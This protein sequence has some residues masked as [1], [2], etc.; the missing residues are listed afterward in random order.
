VSRR[1]CARAALAITEDVSDR[2]HQARR[3]FMLCATLAHSR[4][5]GA[6]RVL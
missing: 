6:Y 5:T 2:D 1:V 4:V 3:S